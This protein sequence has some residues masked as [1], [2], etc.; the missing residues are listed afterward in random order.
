MK[1]LLAE[2]DAFIRD[3]LAEIL[4]G[5]GD[6]ARAVRLRFNQIGLRVREL[7]RG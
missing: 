3:G 1:V 5:D 7:R 4:L 6:R 2:D